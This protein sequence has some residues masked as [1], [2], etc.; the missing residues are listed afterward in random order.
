M[1]YVTNIFDLEMYIREIEDVYLTLTEKF[2]EES[3]FELGN[4]NR[5]SVN[6]A[7]KN[8]KFISK[9]VPEYINF[10]NMHILDPQLT[11]LE[12]IPGFRSRVK[13]YKTVLLKLNHYKNRENTVNKDGKRMGTL[14]IGKS[15]ND[16]FGVRIFVNNLNENSSAVLHLLKN[17]GIKSIKRP[18]ERN[19]GYYR[20]IHLYLKD[21]N[22]HF[23]WEI[24]LWDVTCI[25]KNDLA[26]LAHE[27]ERKL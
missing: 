17:C 12:T 9:I 8:P 4:L 21:S 19:D 11:E 26:H 16:L 13:K 3:R 5:L 10:M 20:A 18:Y 1:D 15:L 25:E 23:S 2:Y 14:Y 6:D 24:Q 7:L 27:E 22:T